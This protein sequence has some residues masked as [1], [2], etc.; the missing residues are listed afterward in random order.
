[1]DNRNLQFGV[2]VLVISTLMIAFLLV[3]YFG[4]LLAFG[5][6]RYKI[7]VKLSE[8]RGVTAGTPVRK[9]GILIGRVEGVDFDEHDVTVTLGIQTEYELT[10]NEICRI[11]TGNLFGDAVLEFV[12]RDDKQP[13]VKIIRH[14][15]FLRGEVSDDPLSM[16]MDLQQVVINLEDDVAIALSSVSMAG[17]EIGTLAQNINAMMGNNDGEISDLLTSA[18][19]TMEN[20]SEASQV[21]RDIISDPDLQAGLR[22]TVQEIPQVLT[23]VRETLSGLQRL[24]DS[25]ANNLQ[26]MERLTDSL[27]DDGPEMIQRIN[28]DLQLLDAVLRELAK[29]GTNINA[30]QGTV[31]KLLNDDELYDRLNRT[32]A[33]VEQLTERL[34]PVVDDVRVFTDKIARDPR[35]LGLRGALDGRQSGLK[36][37]PGRSWNRPRILPGG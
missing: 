1:M 34:R 9:H 7:H 5:Q 15:D 3:M 16:L 6:G 4:E 30:G 2:G 13:D 37:G 14:G 24:T 35:Q 12:R 11:G 36:S 29:V 21:F 18:T 20:I 25:A 8:A 23:E 26:N 19:T 22:T 17:Q 28:D 33:N 31:G 27:A 32:V 10:T